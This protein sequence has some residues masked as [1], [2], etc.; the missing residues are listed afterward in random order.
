MGIENWRRPRWQAADA[1]V[2]SLPLMG[3]ENI[4]LLITPH[5]DRKLGRHGGSAQQSLITP[6]GD[7]KLICGSYTDRDSLPLMG[8]ENCRGTVRPGHS[9]GS[10]FVA[11]DSLPLMGIETPYLFR[12]DTR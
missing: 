2:N 6:H 3:I 11:P 10:D 9:A 5:G 8:I 4:P 7:R 12:T 1:A